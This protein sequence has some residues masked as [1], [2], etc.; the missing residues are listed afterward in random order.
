[1]IIDLTFMI[2]VTVSATAFILAFYNLPILITGVK[3]LLK[4]RK[5]KNVLWLPFVYFYWSFQAFVALYAIILMTLRK[6][7]QWTRTARS[8][9]VD[10][11]SSCYLILTENND[12]SEEVLRC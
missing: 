5:I 1:M 4:P 9:V 11:S 12:T 10:D 7:K 6:T 2:L 3:S 8:G